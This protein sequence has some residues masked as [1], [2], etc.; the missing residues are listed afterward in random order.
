MMAQDLVKQEKWSE[1]VTH[2]RVAES[3]IEKAL[4]KKPRVRDEFEATRSAILKTITAVEARGSD[5]DARFVD[6]QTRIG[7]LK[8]FT[9]PQ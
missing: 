6:L 4:D 7:T 5:L 9:S 2:L 3:H 8:V 1:A